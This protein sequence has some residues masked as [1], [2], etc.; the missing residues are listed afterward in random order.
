MK[1]L[2]PRMLT[3]VRH[4]VAGKSGAESARLAGYDRSSKQAAER[5][6]AHPAIKAE[7]EKAKNNIREATLYDA[8]KAMEEIDRDLELVRAAKQGTAIAS[9]LKLKADLSGLLVQR[10]DQRVQ[11]GFTIQIGGIADPALPAPE[12]KL[13]EGE[14]L[15]CPNN[16]Q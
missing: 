5:L 8:Q 1:E 13:I 10:I 3:F 16:E 4:Y 11:S 7:V 14:V 12:E 15:E 2:S 9:L 6:L